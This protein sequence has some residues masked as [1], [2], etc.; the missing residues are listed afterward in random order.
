MWHPRYDETENDEESYKQIILAVANDI[1]KRG[2]ISKEVFLN[3]LDWKTPRLKGIVK[4]NNFRLYAAKIKKCLK[5]PEDQKLKILDDLYGIGAPLASTILHFIYSDKFPIMDI[6]TVETLYK[7]GYIKFISR[8]GKKYPA[9]KTA[10]L[11]IQRQSPRW[12]LR[13]ID[14]ALFAFHKLNQKVKNC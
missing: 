3:I 12:N 1:K 10:I 8:D 9:F 14:R 7:S 11:S 4:L 6:R 13:Q 5:V 2:T